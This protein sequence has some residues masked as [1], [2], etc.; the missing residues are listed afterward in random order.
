MSGN[1][2]PT[3]G[4]FDRVKK[5]KPMK[6]NSAMT[7]A[8]IHKLCNEVKNVELTLDERKCTIQFR[9]LTAAERQKLE[10][11]TDEV[12]PPIIKGITPEQD[13]IEY[14]NSEFIKKKRISNAKARALA[15]YWCVPE[16]R[17]MKP[18]LKEYDS[19]MD[20]VQSSFP[21]AVLVILEQSVS[22]SGI[23]TAEMVNFTSSSGSPES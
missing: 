4:Q 13:R 20:F 7:F 19:I 1:A 17:A 23:T 22:G 9:R 15:I 10:C 2:G 5:L 12:M 16:L 3:V 6:K 8:E 18:D 11:I 14:T 21:E